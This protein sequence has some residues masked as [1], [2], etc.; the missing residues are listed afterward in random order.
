MIIIPNYFLIVFL[1]RSLKQNFILFK[2]S[3]EPPDRYL[4]CMLSDRL[5]SGL[6]IKIRY[7]IAIDY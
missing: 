6:F 5:I 3:E 1:P 7:Q 2:H 4:F